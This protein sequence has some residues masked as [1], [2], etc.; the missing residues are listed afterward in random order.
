MAGWPR[1]GD[2]EPRP[3]GVRPRTC[4][5]FCGALIDAERSFCHEGCARS[6]RS[7][8]ARIR[9]HRIEANPDA[10]WLWT[11]PKNEAGYGV[12]SHQGRSVLV[13]RY[14]LEQHLGRKLGADLALHICNT[15][16]CT[17]PH[18][19]YAGTHA[20]NMRDVHEAN[21]GAG[22]KTSWEDRVL[23][24]ERLRA[25]EAAAEVAEAYGVTVATCRR[26]LEYFYPSGSEE[27]GEVAELGA[28]GEAEG[29]PDEAWDV[30]EANGSPGREAPPV[31]GVEGR[32][33]EASTVPAEELEE[34]AL[35][36]DVE[37]DAV[38]GPDME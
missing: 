22:R 3:R 17:S 32:L 1:W 21:R 4:C 38:P 16:S 33:R 24:A 20:E 18:H 2:E 37:L 31:P 26:W 8:D 14:V 11:G 30:P 10:C 12:L 35:P 23:I 9:R 13:H 19:L 29:D 15:P 34:G 6:Y 5:R 25:G 36:F 27:L 7:L 28:E